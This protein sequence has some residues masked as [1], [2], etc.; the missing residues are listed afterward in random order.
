MVDFLQNPN[1]WWW[2]LNVAY[3]CSF[4]FCKCSE[5]LR[6]SMKKL[7]RSAKWCPNY[8]FIKIKIQ[9][10]PND[11]ATIRTVT[12]S[13]RWLGP[14]I[15]W[16]KKCFGGVYS[17]PFLYWASNM[18][19]EKYKN[20]LNDKLI[21]IVNNDKW[22]M[23][24]KRS[25][26]KLVLMHDRSYNIILIA[27]PNLVLVH[28]RSYMMELSTMRIQKSMVLMHDRMYKI[29]LDLMLMDLW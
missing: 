5:N 29:G 27:F 1:W 7:L 12:Q 8:L 28:D 16:L 24:A 22:S 25:G 3:S 19:E 18:W 21:M 23:I 20:M 17:C 14:F 15:V 4:L 11:Y 9:D 10:H 2:V 26:W 13:F 6:N